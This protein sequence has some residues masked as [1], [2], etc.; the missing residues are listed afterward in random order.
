MVVV[1]VLAWL[2]A[3]VLVPSDMP[4][5]VVVP[6][7]IFIGGIGASWAARGWID[8][9]D[10]S[11]RRGGRLAVALVVGLSVVAW[12]AGDWPRALAASVLAALL[13]GVTVIQIAA[14]GN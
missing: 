1:T 14:Q 13:A 10:Q 2:F 9:V 3:V 7:V 11:V 6:L 12:N 5:R 4:V 8:R